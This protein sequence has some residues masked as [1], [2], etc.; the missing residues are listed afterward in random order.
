MHYQS[1][2]RVYAEDTD[3]MGLVYHANFLCFFE[4]ARTE[5]LRE[6]QWSLTQMA[7]VYDRHFVI[8]EVQ[9][10]FLHPAKLDD[11]LLVRTKIIKQSACSILFEQNLQ[12]QHNRLL[13][14]AQVKVVCVDGA[15]NVNRIPA[16]FNQDEVDK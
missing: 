12:N 7:D 2:F 3:M 5:M 6:K 9:M 1:H 8:S 16:H 4:R 14:E 10:R 13:C 15:M 11:L